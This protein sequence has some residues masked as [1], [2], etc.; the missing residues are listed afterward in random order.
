MCEANLLMLDSLSIQSQSEG[1]CL[2]LNES[3]KTLMFGIVCGCLPFENNRNVILSSA[4]NLVHINA[5]EQKLTE[6]LE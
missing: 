5:L 6:M 1:T 3:I 4:L 2:L